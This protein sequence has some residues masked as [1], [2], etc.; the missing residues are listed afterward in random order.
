FDHLLQV[1]AIDSASDEYSE[2]IPSTEGQRRLSRAVGE[3]FAQ[4]GCRVE[5]DRNANVIAELPGRGPAASDP[6]VALMVHLDTA[7]GTRAVPRLS[8]A[9]RWDG[10]RIPYPANPA[11]QV[12]VETYPAT[13]AFVGQ[14][15]VYGPGDCPFGLDD[16][17]G[18]AHLMT[19]TRLLAANSGIGHP[20]LLLIGRPD[21]E[22][23][24]M[25][26]VEGLAAELERRGVRYGYTIDG[27]VPFEVNVE[28]FHAAQATVTFPRLPVAGD[29]LPHAI[30]VAIGGVNTHG[31]TA[32]AEGYRAATRFASQVAGA[33]EEAGLAPA[34]IL[35][36]R[37]MTDAARE[38]DA[39]VVFRTDGTP[40]VAAALRQAIEAAIDPHLARG[41]SYRVGAQHV[42]EPGPIDGAVAEMLRF[43]RTFLTS[44]PGFV[45]PAEA[46]EGREG[47]SNPFRSVPLDA[48]GV[49]LDVRLRDFDRA[50]LTARE[51]HVAKVAGA[52]AGA[53]VAIKQQYV[54]MGPRLA[55]HAHLV[56][57]PREAAAALGLEAPV[58][59]IRGG[60]GVDPFLDRGI[61]VANLGTG[62][63]A[64]ESEKEFT[65]LQLMARH[66]LWLTLLVQRLR[67]A[68]DG[69]GA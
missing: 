59:P 68:P 38:C 18:L 43:V 33:L 20:P 53:R 47:Y 30:A 55:P 44:A 64:P 34:R 2:S 26:A 37:F 41:A 61:P 67:T 50:A 21:E 65:S 6:P 27:I 31:C 42:A 9:R 10:R 5:T 32:K 57:W 36:A 45:L 60:T 46:S 58:L 28:N 39:E 52:F 63:F 56:E 29:G 3:F 16:K 22:I 15:L 69:R 8:V 17:L 49:A 14:D 23:G 13:A 51:E 4:Q 35:P 12:G 11:L 54:N 25:A 24:R 48:G 40:E 1:V 19:L 66:A 7:R 62:Y